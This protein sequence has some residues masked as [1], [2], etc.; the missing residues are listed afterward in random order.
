M[1]M[2]LKPG[3]APSAEVEDRIRGAIEAIIVK[4]ARP[5][6]V[7]IVPDM[8]KTRSGKIMRRVVAGLSNFVSPGDI[9]TLANPGIVETICRQVQSAKVARG[10]LPWAL[11]DAE[12]VGIG[13]YEVE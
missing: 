4:I 1:Y 2:A 5:K 12:L 11:S 7:W 13:R 6:N 8:P 9:T 3:Y 10:D